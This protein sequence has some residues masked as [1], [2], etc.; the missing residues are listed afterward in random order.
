MLR[1]QFITTVFAC[2]S[3]STAWAELPVATVSGL[4]PALYRS[5]NMSTDALQWTQVGIG[6]GGGTRNMR[7]HP[8]EGSPSVHLL[9]A[10]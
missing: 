7:I 8:A 9:R 10:G 1:S 2:V 3:L 5:V 6:Q 4:D